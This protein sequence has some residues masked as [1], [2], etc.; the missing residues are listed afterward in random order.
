M[1]SLLRPVPL[2]VPLWERA[3]R[4]FNKPNWV[5][6]RLQPLTHLCLLNVTCWPLPQGERAQQQPPPYRHWPQFSSLILPSMITVFHFSNSA[7]RI[8]APSCTVV[9]RGSTPTLASAV[10]TSV[11]CSVVR[12][13]LLSL[14][15]ASAGTPAGAKTP[16]QRS[17]SKP[18]RPA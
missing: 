12:R 6:G 17:T 15:N 2:R 13:A 11:F 8:S 16:S 14:L 5:R 10:L 3:T 7:F 18:F 4:R 1:S 9:P